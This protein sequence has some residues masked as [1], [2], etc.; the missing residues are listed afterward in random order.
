MMNEM[1]PPDGPVK[2]A[3]IGDETDAKTER[4]KRVARYMNWQ[5][6]EQMTSAYHEFEVG[7]TQC[8]LGGA[9]YTKGYVDN[10]TPNSAFIAID[11]VYRPWNDGDF[12]SQ[13]RITHR[14]MVDRW[15]YRTNVRRGIWTRRG[16]HQWNRFWTFR[17]IFL[18]RG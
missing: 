16:G 7:F 1:L 4:A 18:G 12:Y 13:P 14:Q 17:A 10:G 5:L 8:P 2:A 6:T 3:I 15:T 11:D 9:F